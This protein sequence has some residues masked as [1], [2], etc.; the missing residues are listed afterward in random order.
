M[1]RLGVGRF[2]CVFVRMSYGV[3]VR[4][5]DNDVIIKANVWGNL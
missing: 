2:Q 3:D 1:A 4:Y 5:T